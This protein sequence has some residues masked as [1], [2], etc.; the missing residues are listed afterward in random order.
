MS[1]I[2][3]ALRKSE[4]ER[5]RGQ[6]PGLH[7][8][9]PPPHPTRPAVLPAWA[10][11]LP[12]CALLLVAAWWLRGLLPSPSTPAVPAP[13]AG[14]AVVAATAPADDATAQPRF[15]LPPAVTEPARPSASAVPSRAN[16]PATHAPPAAATTT[17][18]VTTPPALPVSMPANAAPAEPPSPP[19]PPSSDALLQ[20]SDLP[21]EERKSLPPLRLSMHLWNPD[22]AK[23]FAILDGNRVGEGDR[24]GDAVVAAI[25]RDGVVLDWNGRRLQV[26]IR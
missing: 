17:P 7:A 3:E 25:T 11:W 19:S 2:L 8:E 15:R 1:L 23:R 20:L 12:A 18:S 9:L 5:R 16:L 21:A 10:W 4:A 24:V 22:P 6:A 14:T 13:D 26:P